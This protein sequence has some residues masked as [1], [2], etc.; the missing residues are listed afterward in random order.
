MGQVERSGG[1]ARRAP[2]GLE[3]QRGRPPAAPAGDDLGPEL[4]RRRE[5]AALVARL[6]ELGWR[7][8]EYVIFEDGLVRYGLAVLD[9]WLRTG[10]VFRECRSRL[11]PVRVAD[12][13]RE[14]LRTEAGRDDRQQ[15][16]HDVVVAALPRFRRDALVGRG[17]SE[18]LGAALRTYFVGALLQDFPNVFRRWHTRFDQDRLALPTAD[19]VL[20]ALAERAGPDGDPLLTVLADAEV[21]RVLEAVGNP[22]TRQMLELAM[23]GM[24]HRE[25]ARLL[26]IAHPQT[27]TQRIHRL[28]AAHRR[29]GPPEGDSDD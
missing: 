20:A 11:R 5:D 2:G 10:Q 15:I 12:R 8:P 22:Q 19:R 18:Q 4:R 25:I 13:A 21:A 23:T 17:W 7:G 14:R 6:E 24:T 29:G 26:G 3:P 16:A 1:A 9:R 27:V 28:R